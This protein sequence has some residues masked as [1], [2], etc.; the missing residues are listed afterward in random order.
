MPNAGREQMRPTFR[1]ETMFGPRP[2]WSAPPSLDF[3][4]TWTDPA[5]AELVWELD[6]MHHPFAL[7]PLSTDFVANAS[8]AGFDIAYAFFGLPTR[9]RTSF[10]HGYAYTAPVWGVPDPEV[11]ALLRRMAGQFRAFGAETEAYWTA[12][13][14]ELEAIYEQ[15]ASVDVDGLPGEELAAAWNEAWGGLR[16]AWGIHMVVIRGPYRITEDLATLYARH[17][18]DA[19]AGAGYRLIQGQVDVLH[20]VELGIERLAALAGASPAIRRAFE[21]PTPPTPAEIAPVEGGE[22]LLAALEAFIAAHGHI[23]QA[24]S[25]LSQPSWAED[26]GLVLAEVRKRLQ[27]PAEPAAERRRR[28]LAE[29]EAMAGDVRSRLAA[30]P[31]ALAE[32]EAVLALARRIGP[33]TETHNY[34]IDRMSQ[35]RM[36]ALALR[37]GRRLVREGVIER[38][39]DVEYL[40]RTEI[41]DLVVR[42]RD[43]SALVA[44][45]RAE[46]ERQ[47]A[48]V[49]PRAIGGGSAGPPQAR[50]EVQP[51][52]D[53]DAGSVVELRGT[54]ASAGVVKG[55]ARVT[56]GPDEFDRIGPGDIIVCPAT[57]PSWVPVF[58]VAAGLVTNTGGILAHA[59]VVAREF[60]LPAVV[61]VAG[62]TARIRDGAPIEI[63][64]TTGVVRVF[65]DAST[66][67]A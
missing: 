10:H 11:P 51:P 6:E 31:D 2:D 39:A 20:E 41:A 54:G 5:D 1:N 15:M 65:E 64:G 52:A 9:I 30:D 63:D 50:P 47:R 17:V 16:R 3:D 38:V 44:E 60:G 66:P 56:L 24:W 49:P 62:A 28:L 37:M 53:G 36:R 67:P 27:S 43:V 19:P 48:M 23:G 26:P 34:W 12:A 29:A 42:A 7:T 4:L 33:L 58:T 21:G 14:V 18:P 22:E 55:R 59:A 13:L 8:G 35:A 32:F 40:Y 57:T 46:H 25:D 61:G 45:R